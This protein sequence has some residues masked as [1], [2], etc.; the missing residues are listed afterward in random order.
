MSYFK[1]FSNIYS[2]MKLP[3]RLNVAR[4]I[5]ILFFFI[6]GRLFVR[7][8]LIVVFLQVFKEYSQRK[9]R[10]RGNNRANAPNRSEVDEYENA[11]GKY[12][13]ADYTADNTQNLIHIII[14]YFFAPQGKLIY[15]ILYIRKRKGR[16]VI[17]EGVNI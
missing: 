1:I 15:Y 3:A 2:Q 7:V 10:R 16:V 14:I 8:F 12:Q 17:C 6:F 5:C 4:A 11:R 13:R 9:E